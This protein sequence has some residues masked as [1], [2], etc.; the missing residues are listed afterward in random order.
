MGDESVLRDIGPKEVD[1]AG[2]MV[3]RVGVHNQ[4]K[5]LITAVRENYP[6]ELV[7][8]LSRPED[9][10]RTKMLVE[11]EVA[12]VVK[13]LGWKDVDEVEGARV[14]GKGKN[15]HVGVVFRTESG[16]SA[17]GAIPYSE[18]PRSDAAYDAAISS[19]GIVLTDD[20]DPTQLRRALEETQKRLAETQENGGSGAS[21]KEIEAEV[22]KRVEEA[23][24]G[25]REEAEQSLQETLQKLGL[26]D[27]DGEPVEQK[28]PEPYK[29]YEDDNA[30]DV[31][32][33]LDKLDL[34]QLAAL[35]VAEEARENP[36]KSV[37][38][39]LAKRLQAVED[40]LKAE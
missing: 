9:Q 38:E 23:K 30:D 31:V 22:E 39:P 11:D 16:R 34:A 10:G 14:Y 1:S 4:A 21:E 3:S 20:E 28:P 7:A 18:F 12:E 6:R 32:D 26:V 37:L 25:L 8:A 35:K 13:G 33:K 15:A 17:R 24:A 27:E 36:R 5:R 19:G 29:G 40:A 2:D